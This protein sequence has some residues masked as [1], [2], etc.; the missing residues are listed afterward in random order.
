[1]KLFETIAY[2]ENKL[3][4]LEEHYNRLCSS[5]NMLKNNPNLELISLKT[6]EDIIKNQ[7]LENK[8]LKNS[9]FLR[10]RFTV[11]TSN[12]SCSNSSINYSCTIEEYSPLSLNDSI[13]LKLTLRKSNPNYLYKLNENFPANKNARNLLYFDE[14]DYITECGY[15]NIF[16]IDEINKKIV[17][18]KID[19]S[20]NIFLLPGIIREKIIQ[21]FNKN[22]KVH[23]YTLVEKIIKKNEID[24]FS[25]AFITNSLIELQPVLII[26]EIK[27]MENN[28]QNAL[29]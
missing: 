25:S 11:D 27:L 12:T 17:T 14:N 10:I 5:F 21:L 19:K 13:N 18:P 1:M 23:G 29:D 26:D 9:T 7:L 15:S 24:N 22:I 3:I 6:F 28:S 8:N 4:Y 20:N 16:F 2:K